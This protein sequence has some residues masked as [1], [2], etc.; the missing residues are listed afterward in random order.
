MS[1]NAGHINQIEIQQFGLW[2]KL[3]T[4]RRPMSFDAEITPRCNNACRHCYVREAPDDAAI[5]ERELTAAEWD[6]IAAQAVELGALWCLITGGEP[7]IHPDFAHIYMNMKRRGL[8]VSVFTNACLVTDEVIDLFRAYPPRDIE[9]SVYGATEEVYDA[10]TQR[11]GSFQAFRRGLDAMLTEGIRIRLKAMVLRS[12]VHQIDEIHAFCKAHTK[13]YYR[14]DPFLTLRHDQDPVRNAV[15]RSERLS[16]EEVVAV[17]RADPAR[18]G[19]LEKSCDKLVSDSEHKPDLER[20]GAC[21]KQSA[22]EAYAAY[23]RLIG[24]GAGNGSFSVSWDGR[25]ALCQSLMHP[26]CV[27]DLRVVPLRQAWEELVPQVRGR[28]IQG[29]WLLRH[30]K[31]CPL[32]NLCQWC[33]AHAWLETGDLEGETHW[34]CEVACARARAMGVPIPE[35]LQNEV[36]AGQTV[37]ER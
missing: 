26:E 10:V 18:F 15:V 17:E 31:R 34:F 11:P 27:A 22:C 25:F 28:R 29:D 23:R 32:V 9:V 21:E 30:C 12:N 35:F 24:C 5:R 13:D 4:V 37:T 7:L 1:D 16:A 8:L 36:L 14:F 20:C 3:K 33:P 19:A 2:D 6:G